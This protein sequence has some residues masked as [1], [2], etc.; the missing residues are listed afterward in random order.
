MSATNL[1]ETLNNQANKKNGIDNNL[2]VKLVALGNGLKEEKKKNAALQEQI[3]KLIKTN[4]ELETQNSD[5]EKEN[6]NLKVDNASKR[7][8]IEKLK[9]QL[10]TFRDK[11]ASKKNIKSFITSFL[12]TEQPENIEEK[13]EKEQKIDNLQQENIKLQNELERIKNV[14]KI[15]DEQLNQEKEQ[16]KKLE[17]E[18]NNKYTQLENENQKKINELN[19]EL[20]NTKKQFEIKNSE[21]EKK[22]AE[23]EIT[24]RN[25]ENIISSFGS[26]RD[27]KEND[28]NTMREVVRQSEEKLKNKETEL[29]KYKKQNENM[30]KA[31]L[32]NNMEIDNLKMQIQ[33]YKY[34]IEDL[35][36]LNTD[37]TFKGKI[38]PNHNGSNE[39]YLSNL[40]INFGKY[41]GIVYMKIDDKEL[42]LMDKEI[43]DVLENKYIPGQIKF[44]LNINDSDSQEIICQFTK[45]EGE[46]IRK[47][48]R[49]FK[50]HTI[51]KDETLYKMSLGNYFY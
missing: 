8:L 44:I 24:L 23:Y 26:L 11:N 43:V 39:N 51:N 25:K 40:E 19:E 12:D 33:Q 42:N 28:V 3:D 16:I 27:I 35:T 32:N 5:Y 29:L 7:E 13:D 48:F 20:T 31:I 46:Y 34:I 50:N 1:G 10:Q 47:F 21:N 2:L 6:S 4:K 38:V 15:S 45:K 18:K 17:E 37:Y 49:D 22:I 30:N 9:E 36:P 14:L 41:E